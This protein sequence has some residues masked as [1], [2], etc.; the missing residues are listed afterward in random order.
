MIHCSFAP[1]YRLLMPRLRAA[2]APSDELDEFYDQ[3]CGILRPACLS[4]V[5]RTSCGYLLGIPRAAEERAQDWDQ[6]ASLVVS[7]K[8]HEGGLGLLTA[9]ELC[10]RYWFPGTRDGTRFMKESIGGPTPGRWRDPMPRRSPRTTRRVGSIRWRTAPPT[11]LRTGEQAPP[12]PSLAG[13][14]RLELV[15]MQPMA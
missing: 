4:L 11:P 15:G 2:S 6:C 1:L 9:V 3:T 13:T 8:L 12:S 7:S 14:P 10:G 5:R